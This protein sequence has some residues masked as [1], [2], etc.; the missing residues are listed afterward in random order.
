MGYLS[1]PATVETK[2][3]PGQGRN[4]FYT[5]GLWHMQL[6]ITAYAVSQMFDMTSCPGQPRLATCYRQLL[7]HPVIDI[8]R[9]LRDRIRGPEGPDNRYT[10]LS[11]AKRSW[12]PYHRDICSWFLQPLSQVPPRKDDVTILGLP[13]S[14]LDGQEVDFNCTVSRILPPV[15]NMFWIVDG[16]TIQPG[17]ESFKNEDGTFRHSIHAKLHVSVFLPSAIVVTGR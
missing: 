12:L 15:K 2:R 7:F 5:S 17:A 1:T 11:C 4:R 14:A 8:S 9:C 16:Q 10:G 3:L 13:E 6:R